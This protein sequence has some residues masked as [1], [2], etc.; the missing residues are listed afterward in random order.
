MIVPLKDP[1]CSKCDP[2]IQGLAG[3][4]LQHEHAHTHTHTHTCGKCLIYTETGNALNDGS[5]CV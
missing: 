5:A 3:Y 4:T 1:A 2:F